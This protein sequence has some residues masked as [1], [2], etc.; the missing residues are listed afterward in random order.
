M[1]DR[2]AVVPWWKRDHAPLNLLVQGEFA[3]G[4][5]R[6]CGRGEQAQCSDGR[7]EPLLQRTVHESHAC[8]LKSRVPML[9]SKRSRHRAVYLGDDEVRRGSGTTG[10]T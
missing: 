10:G 4:I 7:E 5:L 3:S 2:I 6:Q 8:L 9:A 1:F